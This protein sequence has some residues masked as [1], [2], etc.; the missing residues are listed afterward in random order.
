MVQQ[1][2][3]PFFARKTI[4]QSFHSA[5]ERDKNAYKEAP[6]LVVSHLSYPTA[7]ME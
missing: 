2:E 3:C 5:I 1:Y 7:E 4:G 6:T